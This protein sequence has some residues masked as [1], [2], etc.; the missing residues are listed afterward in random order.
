[1]NQSLIIL[2][3]CVSSHVTAATT[4]AALLGEL[5]FQDVLTKAFGDDVV[6]RTMFADKLIV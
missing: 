5:A 6:A 3:V 1:M 2:G 4:C